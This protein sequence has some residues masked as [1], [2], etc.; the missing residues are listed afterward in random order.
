MKKGIMLLGNCS[1]KFPVGL[2]RVERRNNRLLP[3]DSQ[4]VYA[5]GFNALH[6]DREGRVVCG[7]LHIRL[8]K[9]W[10]QAFEY[11]TWM[12]GHFRV[13]HECRQLTIHLSLA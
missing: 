12:F 11:G 4:Y 8:S 5:P 6:A 9:F 13:F 1:L 2:W 7:V 3:W 10:D